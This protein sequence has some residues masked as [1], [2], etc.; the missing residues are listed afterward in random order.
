MS[1]VGFDHDFATA[2]P[3]QLAPDLTLKVISSTA[4]MLLKI[5]HG[6]SGAAGQ[7]L[8]RDDEVTVFHAFLEVWAQ[9]AKLRA[10]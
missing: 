2:K 6:R 8:S 3:V 5:V 7:G 10:G 9:L 4:L 1:L